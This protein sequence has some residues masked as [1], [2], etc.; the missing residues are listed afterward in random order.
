MAAGVVTHFSFPLMTVLSAIPAVGI[1][2][3]MLRRMPQHPYAAI[4]LG[5]MVVFMCKLA[6][7]VAARIVYGPDY[8]ALG[9]AAA[10][11]RTAKLMIS[12]L[13]F[14][15]TALSL[16]LLLADYRS[17]ARTTHERTV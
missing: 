2:S 4:V 12:V 1:V 17:C 3:W 15:S 11:W 5:G 6:G 9:Y 8:L 13:W 16:G 7:C 10:D 14:L